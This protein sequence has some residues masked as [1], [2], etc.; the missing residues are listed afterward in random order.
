MVVSALVVTLPAAPAARPL[1]VATLARDPRLMLG[2][3]V[4]DRLPLVAEVDSA[5]E[6]AAL[7]DELRAVDGVIAVD[8]VAI[9]F[10][11]P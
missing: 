3:A 11:V 1:V 5:H 6:G 2:A 7:V 10:E 8:V 9:D 4:Q